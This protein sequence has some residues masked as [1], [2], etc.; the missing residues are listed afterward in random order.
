[1]DLPITTKLKYDIKQ[2]EDLENFHEINPNL[3]KIIDKYQDKI[4]FI[5]N[6]INITEIIGYFSFLAFLLMLTIRLSPNITFSWLILLAPSIACLVSFTIL[7]NMYLKLKDIFDESENF[8]E[9]KNSSIGSI[10]T[11][12]CLNTA[13]IC[14]IIFLVLISLKLQGIIA[15]KLNE[16]SIPLYLLSGIALFYYIFIFPAFVKNKLI[17]PLVML[18]VY[19]V[20][21]FIFMVLL[22]W[23][24]S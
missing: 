23:S 19:L 3:L 17:F 9:E 24:K 16:I 18:G 6:T 13:S 1:M 12:F 8:N 10:L 5:T 14:I 21:S 11:Y 4:T 15:L 2:E 22:I 7:L 20:T